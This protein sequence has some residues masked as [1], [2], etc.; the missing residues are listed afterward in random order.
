MQQKDFLLREIEKIGNLIRAIHQRLF[1]GNDSSSFGIN[2]QYEQI[3]EMLFNEL[4]FDLNIFMAQTQSES[5]EYISKHDGFNVENLEML[6]EVITEMGIDSNEI[7][8]NTYIEKAL[9]IYE[10][11][12]LKDKT[13]SFDLEDKINRI[14]QLII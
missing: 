6:A 11:C 14:K 12:K 3:R 10:I 2:Q 8:Q 1:G 13:F 4:N 7:S 5:E 9:H